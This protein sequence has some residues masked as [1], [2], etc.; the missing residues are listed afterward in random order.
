VQHPEYGWAVCF[1]DKDMVFPF[2]KVQK[3]LA[4]ADGDSVLGLFTA[5]GPLFSNKVRLDNKE[6]G[7]FSSKSRCSPKRPWWKLW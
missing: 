3:Q 2:T 5:I 6:Q 1:S 4:N 7:H